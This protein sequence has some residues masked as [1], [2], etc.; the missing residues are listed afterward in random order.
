MKRKLLIIFATV[1]VLCTAIL[2]ASCDF[3]LESLLN[4]QSVPSGE[5]PYITGLRVTKAAAGFEDSFEYTYN[6]QG[7]NPMAVGAD[8]IYYL[9]IEYNNP[10]EYAISSVKVNN[11]TYRDNQFVSSLSDKTQTCL[12]F[13]TDKTVKTETLQYTVN[14]A[15]FTAN[16]TTDKIKWGE[17]VEHSV[18]VAVHPY[19]TLKLNYMNADNRAGKSVENKIDERTKVY[20]RTEMNNYIAAPDYEGETTVPTKAGGWVFSGWYT[21]PRGPEY[22]KLILD[23]DVYSFWCDM[24]LYAY[25]ERMYEVKIEPLLTE[26]EHVYNKG[27]QEFTKKFSSGAV[28]SG[29]EFG[30]GVEN[31]THNYSLEIPDTIM[32]ETLTVTQNVRNDGMPMF[33]VSVTGN[34]YP[35]VRLENNIF[36]GYN[37][38]TAATCG[39]YVESIGYG[40]FRGCT[41]MAT[42]SFS[43]GSVLKRI[44]DY[45]FEST[46]VL[47]ASSPFTLPATVEYLGLCAFRYS[48]WGLTRNSGSGQGGESVLQIR[49]TWKYIGYKCFSDTKFR[50]IVFKAGC[51]FDSQ[52]GAAEGKNDE[53]AL[54]EDGISGSNTFRVGQNRIGARLFEQCYNISNVVFESNGSDGLNIIPDYCFDAGSW[55]DDP[56]RPFACIGYISFGEGLEVIGERAFNYQVKIPELPLPKSL[57][58]VGRYAFYN[59]IAVTNLNFER[60][61]LQDIA[62]KGTVSLALTN[63][64]RLEIIRGGAFAN[65]AGI[66]VVYITSQYFR[67]YGNGPFQGCPRLKCIIFNNIQDV[68]PTGF[69]S[70]KEKFG[71]AVESGEI[72]DD[73]ILLGHKQSDFTYG[74]AASGELT[75]DEEDMDTTGDEFAITYSN[76]IRIFCPSVSTDALKKDMLIGKEVTAGSQSS[77]TKSFNSQVFVHPLE[78]MYNFKYVAGGEEQNVTVAVQEIYKSSNG[79]P[80]STRIGYSLVY[81]DV[82]ST[83]IVLP[84][85]GDLNLQ[86][87]IVEIAAYAIP[88]SC[89]YLKIP[90]CYTRIEH[91]AFNS[92]RSLST[93]EFEDINTLAYIGQYAFMGTS[94]R[95]FTGGTS[96]KVIGDYAFKSCKSLIWVDLKNTLIENKYDGRMG[97]Y[98]QYKYE[99]ELDD[100]DEDYS[101]SL[102]ASCFSACKNLKWIYLPKNIARLNSSTFAGC[103]SLDTVIIPTSNV[104]EVISG[105]DKDRFY[106]TGQAAAVYPSGKLNQIAIYIHFRMDTV[107]KTLLAPEFI[108]DQAYHTF[109]PDTGSGIPDKPNA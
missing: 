78:N 20:Y 82:R 14:S 19:F 56:K 13:A 51:H 57:K 5:K 81:W 63:D 24:T 41:K 21:D 104:S 61:T 33:S 99:Y 10:A 106:E 3:D 54:D 47:G 7:T 46:E 71:Y 94:I 59:C 16:G 49:P 27:G 22:G 18:S 38:L 85:A 72:N 17:G 95:T 79:Q 103:S 92:C 31:A 48:G 1:L 108:R 98:Y 64:S 91:D 42:L 28:L 12:Q 105:N 69:K 60:V 2:C 8:E 30:K 70:S 87:E 75:S 40:A 50:Q 32:V 74:T 90:S 84:T 101:N 29:R 44:G 36:K 23:T 97:A 76:P 34:E 53:S 9:I 11:I 58:D 86:S 62:R 109:D 88:T 55:Y 107:H 77:G 80:T 6:S 73:E 15:F 4:G 45:A 89:V 96:L 26:I 37:T 52:I 83:E 35:V 25:Y 68:L 67:L 93:V 100:Y 102:G 39:K 43:D 65:L 66:D